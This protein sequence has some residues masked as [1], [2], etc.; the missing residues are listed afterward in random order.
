L[1]FCDGPGKVSPLATLVVG[2][3]VAALVVVLLSVAVQV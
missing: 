1:P 2:V 3:L